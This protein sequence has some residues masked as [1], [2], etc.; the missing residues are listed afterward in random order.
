MPYRRVSNGDRQRLV[1]CFQASDGGVALARHLSINRTT[2]WSIKKKFLTTGKTEADARGGG[3]R[4]KIDRVMVDFSVLLLEADP[5]TLFHRINGSLREAMPD[6]PRVS[7]SSLHRSL[8]L[9][10]I[11]SKQVRNIPANL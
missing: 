1:D 7:I 8:H 5:C 6:K 9:S 3:R 10:L 2:A 4:P 11:S